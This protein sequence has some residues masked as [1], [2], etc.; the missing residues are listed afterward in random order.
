MMLK[1]AMRVLSKGEAWTIATENGEG[2]LFYF[3]GRELHNG[4]RYDIPLDEF[5][6]RECLDIWDRPE[7]KH[8]S[9][10]DRK[11]HP[12]MELEAGLAFIVSGRENGSI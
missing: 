8:W 7:R 2:W 5:T 11:W 9:E 1:K 10:D 6:G 3:D 4:T 12:Y